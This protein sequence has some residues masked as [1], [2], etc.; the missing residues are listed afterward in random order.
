MMVWQTQTTLIQKHAIK[1]FTYAGDVPGGL[2][3]RQDSAIEGRK[4]AIMCHVIK[5][6][7]SNCLFFF[8]N[9]NGEDVVHV[10]K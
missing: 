10:L 8:M 6:I 2:H 3:E 9:I 5:R 1:L 4:L 7:T